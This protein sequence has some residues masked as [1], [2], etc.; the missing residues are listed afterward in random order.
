MRT[1]AA[2][3]H[4]R[5]NSKEAVAE[6]LRG[7]KFESAWIAGPCG[8]W[9]SVWEK[10][11]SQQKPERIQEIAQPLSERL[12]APVLALINH[13]SGFLCYWLVD[14]GQ[15][16]DLYN[17]CPGYFNDD[18]SQDEALS[19]DCAT[20][21][22]YCRPGV[23][24][25]DLEELLKITT[26]A[27]DSEYT[28]SPYMLADERLLA[29][30]PRLEIDPQRINLDFANIGRNVSPA[31]I[32]A[33]WIGTE[34]CPV[35]EIDAEFALDTSQPADPLHGAVHLG[36]IEAIERLVAEGADINEYS[37]VYTDNPL[38]LAARVASP[39]VVRR[40]VELGAEIYPWAGEAKGK[41]AL[42]TAI[43]FGRC[44]NVQTLVEL[45]ANVHEEDPSYGTLLHIAAFKHYPPMAKYLLDLGIDPA[46]TNSQGQTPL[47]IVRTRREQVAKTMAKMPD[48]GQSP[49]MNA[50][51][52]AMVQ[53]EKLLE[54]A[55][56]TS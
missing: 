17:S 22:K 14:N 37:R 43:F 24:Q 52:E 28:I 27:D 11:A 46:R 48:T 40:L 20:L 49:K 23:S 38:S 41:S 8:P 12:N 32:G 53:F 10:Q 21:Q 9:V 26:Q 29:L 1:F 13:D 56:G 2:N 34:P 51:I 44:D 16:L 31:V 39:E 47:E 45:G 35:E 50:R 18:T 6:V 42:D 4:V 15:L 25:E 55:E 36:D 30:A 54:D 7:L 3:F 33:E 19:A 5:I